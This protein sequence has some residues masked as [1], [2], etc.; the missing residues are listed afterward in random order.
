[1][2]GVSRKCSE[3]SKGFAI[4]G[5]DFLEESKF[6]DAIISYNKSLCFALIKSSERFNG[7]LSRSKVYLKLKKYEKCLENIALAR[8]SNY[9]GKSTEK[10]K[11]IEEKC[12]ELM[13]DNNKEDED[14]WNFFKLSD[15]P[16][17]KVPFIASCLKPHD[18]WKYGR[19][20]ITT[21]SLKTGDIVAIEEPLFKMLNKNSR[22][23]R[24]SG[25]M[26]SNL[27]SLLPCSGKCT[28]G[29]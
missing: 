25:C 21:K 23:I 9:D 20:V 19:C 15:T 8:L 17:D 28:S 5:D 4:E 7:F 11:E 3:K 2:E 13:K 6:F 27:G 22:Y 29:E 16:H 12:K 10:L 14:P 18:T 24:C 1:M 26:K